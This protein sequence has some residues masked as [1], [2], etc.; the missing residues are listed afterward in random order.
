MRQQGKH[1]KKLENGIMEDYYRNII[2][3]EN[4][5]RVKQLNSNKEEYRK[6]VR[7]RIDEMDDK[8]KEIIIENK[9]ER[10]NF[11]TGKMSGN[12]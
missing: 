2:Q 12:D 3:R 6:Y 1:A 11:Y 9:N 4:E 5:A 10:R 7:M 8:I